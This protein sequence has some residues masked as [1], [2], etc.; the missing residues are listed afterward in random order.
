MPQHSCLEPQA[1]QP[2][3]LGCLGFM[4]STHCSIKNSEARH[5]ARYKLLSGVLNAF[6]ISSETSEDS[7]IPTMTPMM[8]P[9]GVIILLICFGALGNQC[10]CF[11]KRI[12]A[13][14]KNQRNLYGG[15]THSEACGLVWVNKGNRGMAWQIN[16]S[17]SSLSWLMAIC[18]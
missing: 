3:N 6:F 5:F 9:S 10:L 2:A 7:V 13:N 8:M 17:F 4:Y 11:P 18:S 14:V 12:F 16:I 15:T 1:P